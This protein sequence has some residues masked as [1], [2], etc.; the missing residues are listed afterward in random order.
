MSCRVFIGFRLRRP[1]ENSGGQD[2]IIRL[3]ISVIYFA[4]DKFSVYQYGLDRFLPMYLVV[5]S[6]AQF[7]DYMQFFRN[8]QENSER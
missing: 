8:L 6:F 1:C 2:A 3:L 4:L 7:C 5:Y